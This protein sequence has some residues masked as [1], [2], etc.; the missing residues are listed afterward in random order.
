MLHKYYLDNFYI[1]CIFQCERTIEAAFA[2][3]FEC[4]FSLSYYVNAYKLILELKCFVRFRPLTR[5]QKE[6][7]NVV[8]VKFKSANPLAKASG[9]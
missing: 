2:F 4:V 9:I 1:L 3:I 7:Y 8:I 6:N 5:I